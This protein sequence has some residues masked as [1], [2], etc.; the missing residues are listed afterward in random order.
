MTQ[1]EKREQ[2]RKIEAQHQA[3][4]ENRLKVNVLTLSVGYEL[5]KLASRPDSALMENIRGIRVRIANEYGFVIPKICIAPNPYM[6]FPPNGYEFFLK[7]VKVGGG[8]VE[9]DK[10]LLLSTK[11]KLP[12]SIKGIATKDPVSNSD[13][14][15]IDAKDKDDALLRGDCIVVDAS[16][17]ISTHIGELIKQYLGEI[18]THQDVRD[19]IDMLQYTFPVLVE[20]SLEVPL[21]VIHQVLKDLLRDGIPIKDMITILET[22]IMV[23][24]IAPNNQITILDYVRSALAMTITDTFK[25]DDD[26]IKFFTIPAESESYLL[27]KM[28]DN[29]YGRNFILTIGE[30]TMLTQALNQVVQKAHEMQ[31]SPILVV[32]TNIRYVLDKFAKK[33]GIPLIIL[34]C[35]EIYSNA[36]I[37]IVGNVELKF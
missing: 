28:Q 1:L 26:N 13:A 27:Q 6:D 35:G 23:A 16:V 31:T 2:E 32:D 19:R 14:L 22:I 11:N 34:G 17:V 15:W 21:V 5:I 29:Q 8:K 20:E 36:K 30:T 10:Y 4:L 3:I 12:K 24:H 37:E 25:S 33:N 9:V 18:I 7:G